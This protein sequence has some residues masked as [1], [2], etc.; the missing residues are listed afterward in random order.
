MHVHSLSV[1]Y[2]RR[3]QIKDY[4][5]V[6]AEV[7]LSATLAEGEEHKAAVH[8]LMV[9]AKQGVIESG[10]K[11]GKATA[12]AK[13]ET[14]AAPAAAPAA[15]EKKPAAKP[16][17][18]K[19]KEEPKPAS[20]PAADPADPAGAPSEEPAAAEAP[21]DEFAEFDA[22]PAAEPEVKAISV[23]EL[24]DW[25]T[26]SLK[27]KANGITPDDVKAI[28]S[29]FGAARTSDLKDDDRPKAKVQIEELIKSKRK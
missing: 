7:T 21:A 29:K 8:N 26:A 24:T 1:R 14:A 16:K 12:E 10:L 13:T 25:V 4:E 3:A 22:G 2:M 15:A 5:P 23:K 28:Y 19:P 18:D 27:D 6:E 9:D 20:A 17:A 11:S